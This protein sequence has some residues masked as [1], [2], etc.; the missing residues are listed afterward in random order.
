MEQPQHTSPDGCKASC[1]STRDTGRGRLGPGPLTVQMVGDQC[2]NTTSHFLLPPRTLGANQWD[3]SRR[4]GGL[5]TFHHLQPEGT[6]P[7]PEPRAGGCESTLLPVPSEASSLHAQMW[8][9]T[10]SG[11]TTY[12]ST[13]KIRLFCAIETSRGGCATWGLEKCSGTQRKEHAGF[14]RVGGKRHRTQ[15]RWTPDCLAGIPS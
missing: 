4:S 9:G 13:S 14:S 8:E 2:P 12:A 5:P 7:H 10:G 1:S 15:D 6:F 3:P 11:E